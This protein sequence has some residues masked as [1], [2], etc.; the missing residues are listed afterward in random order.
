MHFLYQPAQPAPLVETDEDDSNDT[1]DS[2]DS[3]LD[4]EKSWAYVSPITSDDDWLSSEGELT[5]L[6]L[7]R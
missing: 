7:P 4:S 2:E 5:S 1:D 3:D 6:L